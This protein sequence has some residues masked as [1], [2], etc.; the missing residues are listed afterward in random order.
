MPT[1]QKEIDGETVELEITSDDLPDGVLLMDEDTLDENYVDQQY[2]EKEIERVRNRFDSD[3]RE[4]VRE[5]LKNDPDFREQ[6]AAEHDLDEERRKEIVQEVEENRV[7]P[8]EEEATAWRRRYKR[9][10]IVSELQEREDVDPK[11]LTSIGS[12]EPLAVQALADRVTIQGDSPDEA[13]VVMTDENGN[14]LPGSDGGYASVA[15]GIDQIADDPDFEP[16][17]KEEEPTSG[18]G[19]GGSANGSASNG[20]DWDEMSTDEKIEA[21]RENDGQ[22]PATTE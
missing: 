20:G 14:P 19:F 4:E 3:L 10:K 5:E 16:L 13:K 2:H 21:L 6:V 7:K 22:H 15:E 8:I 18:S 1:V 12:A 11:A 9:E 17:F